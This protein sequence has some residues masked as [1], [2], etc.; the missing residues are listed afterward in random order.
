M[1]FVGLP[2]Y[3]DFAIG[4]AM[5]TTIMTESKTMTDIQASPLVRS[6]PRTVLQENVE[7]AFKDLSP[8]SFRT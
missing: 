1:W 5:S 7:H 2:C 8:Y 4:I 3:S 6:M